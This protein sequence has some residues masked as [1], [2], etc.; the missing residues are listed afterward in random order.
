MDHKLRVDEQYVSAQVPLIV[1]TLLDTP[2]IYAIAPTTSF[3]QFGTTL[4]QNVAHFGGWDFGAAVTVP[5]GLEFG[6]FINNL[7]RFIVRETMID[8]FLPVRFSDAG[9]VGG[10]I[11]GSAT[12]L[13]IEAD[14]N[15]GPITLASTVVNLAGDATTG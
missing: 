5:T 13:R 11:S 7:S 8:N 3:V 9:I 1:N 6:V 15:A 12:G 14:V 2:Q 4:V 10:T